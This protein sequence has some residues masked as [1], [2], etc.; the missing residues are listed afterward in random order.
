M[1]ETKRFIA[2]AVCPECKAMDKTVLY[3]SDAGQRRECVGCGHIERLDEL[4]TP[5]ELQT[6]VN[7]AVSNPADV[8][9]PIKLIDPRG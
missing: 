8:A 1:V 7:Q 6:R 5:Q 2:G 3:R 9:E 4:G